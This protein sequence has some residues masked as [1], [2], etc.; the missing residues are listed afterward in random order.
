MFFWFVL[1]H[2]FFCSKQKPGSG[3]LGHY[4]FLLMQDNNIEYWRNFVNEYFAPTAKK[5]WCVSLYGSGRQTTGVFPQVYYSFAIESIPF[6]LWFSYNRILQVNC[7]LLGSWR[8]GL[9]RVFVFL[10]TFAFQILVI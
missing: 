3:N 6:F 7:F 1:I 2:A 8:F 10:D 4:S 5:R 9:T